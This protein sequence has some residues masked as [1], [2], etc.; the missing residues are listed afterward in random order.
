[1][2]S[3]FP[4][5]DC[6]SPVSRDVSLQCEFRGKLAW[7]A[8]SSPEVPTR[9]A[10]Q[11]GSKCTETLAGWELDGCASLAVEGCA[12]GEAFLATEGTSSWLSILSVANL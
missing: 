12:A 2:I 8:R 11:A 3:G 4:C 9:R 10:R 1:M 7:V 5:S 6:C